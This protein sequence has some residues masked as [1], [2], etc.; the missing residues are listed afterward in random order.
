MLPS[1]SPLQTCDITRFFR[2]PITV[3]ARVVASDVIAARVAAT[4]V[5]AADVTAAPLS[6]R[7]L[8]HLPKPHPPA[9]RELTGFPPRIDRIFATETS[10]R[11]LKD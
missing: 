5:A 2:R 9:A 7:R 11:Y 8:L 1:A 6:P 3:A 10:K 4:G